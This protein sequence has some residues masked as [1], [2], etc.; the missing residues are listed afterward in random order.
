MLEFEKRFSLQHKNLKKDFAKCF[1][2]FTFEVVSGSPTL[3]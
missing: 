3:P 2:N 1:F